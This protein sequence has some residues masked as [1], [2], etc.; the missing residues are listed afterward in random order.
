MYSFEKAIESKSLEVANG[1]QMST[2][3]WK[4]ASWVEYGI[5]TGH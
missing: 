3:E 4:S 1:Y 5:S 2:A